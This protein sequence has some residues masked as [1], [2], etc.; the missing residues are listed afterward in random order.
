M[1][2]RHRCQVASE[3]NN[4][5]SLDA[6]GGEVEGAQ[7]LELTCGLAVWSPPSNS[8]EARGGPQ[9]GTYIHTRGCGELPCM[10]CSP[11]PGTEILPAMHASPASMPVRPAA[12][13]SGCLGRWCRCHLPAPLL[14]SFPVL[15]EERMPPSTWD[16]SGTLMHSG[17]PLLPPFSPCL[18]L[19]PAHHGQKLDV[20]SRQAGKG[21]VALQPV[22]V[23]A[24]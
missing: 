6:R 17:W 9:V 21:R 16:I 7:R 12:M 4:E 18:L 5:R 23:T 20:R 22:R 1:H 19:A 3:A 10:A 8:P 14:S 24:G 11:L 13:R 15:R 2:H